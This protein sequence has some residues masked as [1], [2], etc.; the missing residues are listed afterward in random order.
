[1]R[2]EDGKVQEDEMTGIIL[3]GGEGSRMKIPKGLISFD[4][5][6]TIIERIIEILRSIFREV[7]VVTNTP[8][9]Y[10][11]FE[12]RPVRNFASPSNKGGISN[13][14]RI[15]KDL[16]KGKGPLGGIYSGLMASTSWYNFVCGC[17]MPFIKPSLIRYL[18][19][20]PVDYDGA[21]RSRLE[22]KSQRD[23]NYDV[24]LPEIDGLAEPLFAIY[25]KGC[26]PIMVRNIELGR[27]KI[28]DIFPELDVKR[29]GKREIDHFDPE[30]L[31]FFNVNTRHDLARAIVLSAGKFP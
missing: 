21:L 20:L 26:I 10:S 7:I 30:H 17:D 23:F 11:K 24:L 29:V 13:G 9:I 12:A 28:Q 4:D 8:G 15:V 6:M 1:M 3:A 14:V 18:K 31:S 5:G 19:A 22:L 2:G 25:S 16:V 27:L